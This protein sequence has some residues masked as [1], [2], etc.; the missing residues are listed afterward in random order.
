MNNTTP[1]Q[2]ETLETY[3]A[4]RHNFRTFDARPVKLTVEFN[5]MDIDVTMTHEFESIENFLRFDDKNYIWINKWSLIDFDGLQSGGSGVNAGADF[6][7]SHTTQVDE[8][9]DE[10]VY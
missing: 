3:Q 7:I 8:N 5:L 10:I 2:I 9:G 6:Y 4:E 1:K